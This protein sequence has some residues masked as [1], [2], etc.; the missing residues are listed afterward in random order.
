MGG[1]PP[2][3]DE[4]DLRRQASLAG[5]VRAGL[6]V[7]GSRGDEPGGCAGSLEDGCRGG[8]SRSSGHGGGGH[9]PQPHPQHAPSMCV[10]PT[11]PGWTLPPLGSGLG[12]ERTPASGAPAWGASED[13]GVLPCRFSVPTFVSFD[14]AAPAAHGG[15]QVSG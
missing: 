6:K 9:V 3:R 12:L 13:T 2:A 5:W 14:T 1:H 7:T 4:G 10:L 15:S 8:S 11:A